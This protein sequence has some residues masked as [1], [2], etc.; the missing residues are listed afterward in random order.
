MRKISPILVFLVALTLS[1]QEEQ[2]GVFDSVAQEVEKK[3]RDDKKVQVDNL[4]VLHREGTVYLEGVTN[5]YGSRYKAGVIAGKQ[6]GVEKVDNQIAL[7]VRQVSDVDI[8]AQLFNKIRKHLRGTP[9]DLISVRV[10]HGIVLLQGNVLDTSLIDETFEEAIWT[11]GVREVENQIQAGSI[12]AGDNRLRRAI[13]DRLKR[14]YPQY[15]IGSL[16]S[17]IIL[18]DSSRVTLVG[19]VQS[20]VDKVKIPSIVRSIQGVLSVEDRLEAQ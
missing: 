3:I 18:V 11:P 10:N 16:P 2:K 1:A 19:S 17:I 9:F 15:F 7:N 13:Y 20:N 4:A 12:S 5:L 8:Q 6:N 14:A